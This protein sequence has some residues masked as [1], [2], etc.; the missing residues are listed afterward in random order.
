[1]SI[2]KTLLAGVAGTLLL[3]GVAAA[4]EPVE[5][6]TTE[7]D[8]VTAGAFNIGALTFTSFGEFAGGRFLNDQRT[9]VDANE[10]TTLKTVNPLRFSGSTRVGGGARTS[11]LGFSDPFVALDGFPGSFLFG[12]GAVDGS[13]GVPE[14]PPAP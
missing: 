10:R 3:G 4:N 7:L 2:S 1:M 13:V 14:V 12:G 9:F 6:T 8:G 11:G 5:L